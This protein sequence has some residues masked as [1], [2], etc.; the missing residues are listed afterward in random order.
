MSRLRTLPVAVL[1]ALAPAALALGPH[2]GGAEIRAERAEAG[3]VLYRVSLPVDW[4]AR[5]ESL[6]GVALVP[7]PLG[8]GYPSLA[9]S[10]EIPPGATASLEVTTLEV[11]Q[12]TGGLPPAPSRRAPEDDGV[13]DPPAAAVSKLAGAADR[14]GAILEDQGMLG[15][16]GFARVRL[17]PLVPGAHGGLA[18]RR[19]F[20][21]R[22]RLEAPQHPV[23]RSATAL[24][25]LAA[26]VL[27]PYAGPAVEAAGSLETTATAE[28]A[29]TR[30]KIEVNQAGIHRVLGSDL[31][32]AG[33]SLAAVNPATLVLASQGQNI[34]IHVIGDGDGDIDP[35][36]EIEF[37]GVPMTGIYTRT[38]VYWL[39]WGG[40]AGPRMAARSAAPSGGATV[41]AS[42][43]W[44]VRA[45]TQAIYTS[46]PPPAALNHWWWDR[47][48]PAPT[49][50]AHTLD[51]TGLSAAAHSVALRVGL[52]G[53]SISGVNPDHHTRIE[54]NGLQVDDQTWDGQIPFTHAPAV[55][56]SQFVAGPNTINLVLPGDTGAAPDLIYTDFYEADY[57]RA[58][59]AQGN[60]LEFVGEGPGTFEYRPS[61]FTSATLE[62]F[63]I[64]AP[65][66]PVRLTGFT[67]TGANP[68]TANVKDS[69]AGI[70]R[71]AVT[72]TS[73]RLT[74][75]AVTLSQPFDLLATVNGADHLIVAP[76]EFAAAV[77]PLRVHRAG[78]GMRALVVST[79]DIYDLFSDGIFDPN[80][81]TEFLA[82]AY[83]SWQPPAPSF[84]VLAGDGSVD[85]QNHTGNGLR[86]HVPTV[87]VNTD[88]LGE[89]PSDNTFAMVSGADSL[90]DLYIGRLPVT[91][92]AE[93][94]A[95]VSK[96]IAYETAPPFIA[97]NSQ[98]VFVADDDD[99]AFQAVL[100]SRIDDF[101]PP[102]IPPNRI[103]LPAASSGAAERAAILA[104]INSGTLM[105]TF[106]GHGAINL[107]AS[108]EILKIA[109]IATLTNSNRQPFL[110]ALNCIN[111]YFADFRANDPLA[112]DLR[113]SLMEE[114][115]RY[116]DR[117]AIAAWAPAS[118]STIGDYD[119]ISYELFANL[120]TL[121]EPRL[122]KAAVD[123]L[124]TSIS[125]YGVDGENAKELTFFGDPA[126]IF[127]LDTDAD[128]AAD[129]VDNCPALANPGQE[130]F[131]GDSQGNA[132]DP[133]D[134]NDTQ[135]DV[136]D[137]APLNGTAFAIPAE[138]AELTV[139]GGP[140]ATLA[141]SSQGSTAGSG[142]VYDVLVGSLSSL[143]T[144]LITSATCFANNTTS[145]SLVYL[146]A[147]PAGGDYVLVRAENACGTGGYGST[148]AGGTRVNTACP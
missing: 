6:P 117:G 22:L 29:P 20:L 75:L 96:L 145:L 133:D 104:A 53:R 129:G 107:W 9:I 4:A 87:M 121:L 38:N 35:A 39:S 86:N 85:Y 138:V 141:W 55:P 109:D 40:V 27:V 130:N 112:G 116:G 63:D 91:T 66:L 65:A 69:P 50:V 42:F 97:L 31:Q 44:T 84:V 148:T 122:G 79:R 99:V 80:A 89:T 18:F 111:G 123:G 70:R 16:R 134:D 131:D 21:L 71:Y 147:P 76:P 2:P 82:Y 88:T 8:K 37:Y 23:V 93:A 67:V 17:F 90:P 72:A 114:A 142:T 92:P 11:R 118:L 77:E 115:V 113:Y 124:I 47:L 81:I 36:D 136:S 49:S 101:L 13:G 127:A 143:E 45:E 26:E 137:C 83:A 120:F 125:L 132:C 128:A 110:A 48:N 61:G 7:G 146:A 73:A 46:N 62:A 144:S 41:P 24:D 102:Q 119:T 28:V 19:E 78:Q 43:P 108:E 3:A 12:A 5:W 15:R 34:A 32:A 1:A 14:V 58:Y 95:M 64:T 100:D 135:P 33:V 52:Q 140:S 30:V 98:A 106:L 10:F 59:A 25:R 139:T 60:R 126:T 74:P 94:T 51:L 56:S 103:Y 68:F 57:R 54:V 105:T